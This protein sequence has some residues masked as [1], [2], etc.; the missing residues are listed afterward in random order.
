LAYWRAARAE[1]PDWRFAMHGSDGDDGKI[2]PCPVLADTIAAHG[3]GWH[4]KP[5][6]DGFGHVIHYLASVGRPLV[7]N[8]RNYAGLFAGPLWEDGVTCIDTQGRAPHEVA[9]RLR[10]VVSD[11]E[12]YVSMC[13]AVRARVDELCDFDAEE[14]LVR[15][16]LGL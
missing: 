11:S 2:G 7:G 6:G 14:L 13:Q 5:H 1:L 3:F 8:S 16:L 15:D 9:E 12:R 4:D 10:E